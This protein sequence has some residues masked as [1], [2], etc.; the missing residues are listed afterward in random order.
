MVHKLEYKL[1]DGA[2]RVLQYLKTDKDSTQRKI[3]ENINTSKDSVNKNIRLLVD[4]NVI[5][6]V[7]KGKGTMNGQSYIINEVEKWTI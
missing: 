7:R 5:Q 3:A 2:F 4:Y 1:N 6:I